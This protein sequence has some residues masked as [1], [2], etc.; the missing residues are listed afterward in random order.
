MRIVDVPATI[1]F[2]QGGEGSG[3]PLVEAPLTFF[4]YLKTAVRGRS[5]G[6]GQWDKQDLGIDVLAKIVKAEKA[7]ADRIEFSETEW[8]ALLEA[9][10]AF[11]WAPD[12]ALQGRA[13]RT[14][15]EK[16]TQVN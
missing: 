10:K 9:A 11:G 15:L 7:A 16:P 2:R 8:T 6:F 4:E 5:S 3:E 1:I 13:Y 12:I 14:A